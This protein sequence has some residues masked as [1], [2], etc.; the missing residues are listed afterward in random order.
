MPNNWR[1]MVVQRPRRLDNQKLVFLTPQS[2]DATRSHIG[3][4]Y[5][6]VRVVNR[7]A[8]IIKLKINM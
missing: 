8:C 5:A 3:S 6:G 4:G 7:Q 2:R 1:V